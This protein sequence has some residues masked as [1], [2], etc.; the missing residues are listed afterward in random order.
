MNFCS[1]FLRLPVFPWCKDSPQVVMLWWE[2]L[3]RLKWRAT[4][5]NASVLFSSASSRCSR[6][7]SASLLPVSR[8]GYVALATHGRVALILRMNGSDR[9]WC[10]VLMF[11]PMYHVSVSPTDGN[12]PTQGQRKTPTRLGFEPTTF[13]F[14]HRCS[15]DWAT[16]SNGSRSSEMKMLMARQ[17]ICR[18][19]ERLRCISNA[20]P[21]F[22][23][24]TT[25]LKYSV[26]SISRARTK[27]FSP[28]T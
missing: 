5:L 19:K 25:H 14:D 9:M 11:Q 1:R 4:G 23:T 20:W 10:K 26:I 12:G 2:W 16:R 18:Y 17:W 8:K 6:R 13:E 22:K 21:S 27:S 7:R 24:A 15:T 3:G 28:W